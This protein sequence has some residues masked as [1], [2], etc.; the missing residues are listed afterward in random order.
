MKNEL[1]STLRFVVLIATP[2]CLVNGLIFSLGS[3]DLIQ[4]WFSRF[5]FTFLVTFPQAVFYVSVVKWF[6]KRNKV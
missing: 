2:L 3:Q 4:A 6:D 5:G 1:K